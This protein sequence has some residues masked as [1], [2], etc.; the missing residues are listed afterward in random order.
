[1]RY[2]QSLILDKLYLEKTSLNLCLE[3]KYL[4]ILILLNGWSGTKIYIYIFYNLYP[5]IPFTTEEI[6][7]CTNEAAKS[8]KKA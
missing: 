6:T 8:A 1:M 4:V 2:A 3:L 5:L 7:G